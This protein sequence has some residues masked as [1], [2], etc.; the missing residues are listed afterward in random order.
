[1]LRARFIVIQAYLQK[2]E[3]N[4]INKLPLHLKQLE[5]E[6]MENSR[7]SGRKEIIKVRAGNKSKI[8]KG[9]YSKNQQS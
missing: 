7:V 6:E 4:Q 9:D 8:N 1:M 5:K 3:K 2:Q